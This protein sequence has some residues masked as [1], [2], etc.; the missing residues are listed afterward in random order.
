MLAKAGEPIN[1]NSS[2]DARAL[3]YLNKAQQ[4]II[5][6]GSIYSLKVDEAF[7]WARARDPVIL[8]LQPAFDTGTVTCASEDA[9]ITFS[10]APSSSLEGWHFQVTGARTIYRIKKHNAGETE[11]VLDSGF[12]NEAGSYSFRAFKLDYEV[13]PAYIYI[14]SH[15][16]KFEFE[17]TAS[18]TLVA[19]L[20]HGSYTPGAF[21]AHL[22]SKMNTV[23]TNIHSG[24]YDSVLKV[25]TVTSTGAGGK[26][27]IL[28][29]T[30]SNF[31]RSPLK[32]LGFDQKDYSGALTY[33]STYIVNGIS[34]MI[35]PFRMFVGAVSESQVTSADPAGMEYDYPLSATPEKLPDRF[36]KIEERNDGT[37]VVR[38]NAYP[39]NLTKLMVDWVPIPRDMQDNAYSFPELP[40]KDVD[41]LIHA[42]TT[43]ILVDKNDAKWEAMLNMTRAGLEA[44]EKK[45]RSEL[46]RTSN[47][48]GQ[49]APR[50]DL[51]Q[52]TKPRRYGYEV[53]GVASS[54]SQGVHSVI[55]NAFGT[56]DVSAASTTSTV[57]ARTMP[58]NHVLNGLIV[59]L[60]T[61]FAA[62]GL[63]AC[64]LD[65]GITGDLTKF[66]NAFDLM[67][68][69]GTQDSSNVIYFP[70]VA[71]EIILTVTA[72]GAN[73]N[74]LTAGAFNV[75]F[76]EAL[77]PA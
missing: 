20:T 58:A 71:T 29:G 31:R 51:L 72:T 3:L 13:F 44:M 55:T 56:S 12:V 14:D 8:E 40:R 39:S 5:A 73:L 7:T 17:Q 54:S 19:T 2:Y 24:S 45:N 77:V 18:T 33:T 69:I 47:N 57:V 34:R 42:A 53:S 46:F 68:A 11:A 4:A 37:Y 38:F 16:D 59:R 63:T 6:G 32:Q 75:H 21:I 70:A 49:I 27:L 61:A 62:S 22:V 23:G 65:I 35:E 1:G 9:N 26:V 76:D 48:F 50:A 41:V 52:V 36:C 43:L 25:F 67:G 15:N 60:T 10:T 74:T 28:K 64:R 66:I 30:A